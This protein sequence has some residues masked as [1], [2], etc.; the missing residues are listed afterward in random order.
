MEIKNG[1]G[2]MW[3]GTSVDVSTTG[4]RVR[5]D[6]P[7]E[8]RGFMFISFHP[9]DSVGPFWTKFSLV[10]EVVPG[11]EYGIRFLDLPPKNVERLLAA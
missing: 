2:K 3:R 10:R 8:L 11:R 1:S 9:G 6:T 4:M 5:V 7:L